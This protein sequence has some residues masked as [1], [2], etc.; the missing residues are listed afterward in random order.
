MPVVRTRV[1]YVQHPAYGYTLIAQTNAMTWILYFYDTEDVEIGWVKTDPYAF[2]IT[3]PD[4]S[5]S[6]SEIRE[7]LERLESPTKIDG[8]TEVIEGW[9]MTSQRL[10]HLDLSGKEHL[11]YIE[12]KIS[13][14]G[15]V[16]STELVD[17]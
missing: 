14:Y 7:R 12:N 10:V 4:G 13:S 15:G 9:T 11:E 3:H 6:Y 17:E 16:G 1:L 8:F 5:E 2:E